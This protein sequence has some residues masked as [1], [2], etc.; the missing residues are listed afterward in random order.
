MIK[1]SLGKIKHNHLLVMVICCAVPLVTIVALSSLGTLGSWSYFALLLLCPLGHF[2][3]MR[4]MNHQRDRPPQQAE[5]MAGA[6][7]IRL[8]ENAKSAEGSRIANET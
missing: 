6:R 2:V 5:N 4:A 3:M 8:S 1:S 7:N